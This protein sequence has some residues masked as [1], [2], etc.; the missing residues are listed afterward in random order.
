MKP[1]FYS[2]W[3]FPLFFFIDSSTQKEREGK[4]F[5]EL[6]RFVAPRLLRRAVQRLAR[7]DV[8]ARRQLFHDGYPIDVPQLLGLEEK[9]PGKTRVSVIYLNALEQQDWRDVT[10]PRFTMPDG[11]S[12]FVEIEDER[13]AISSLLPSFRVLS[14]C[15]ESRKYRHL[16]P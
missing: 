14:A 13:T 3:L 8:G 5:A 12:E 15:D 9:E 1:I 10:S 2:L 7:L 16:F 6:S 11:S 4:D